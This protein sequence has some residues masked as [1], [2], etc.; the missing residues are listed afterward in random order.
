VKLSA[1]SD[2][3]PGAPPPA[4]QYFRLVEKDFALQIDETAQTVLRAWRYNPRGEFGV[5]YLSSRPECAY[6]EK[7][8]QVFGKKHYLKLQVVGQFEVNLPKCLHLTNPDCLT[9]LGVT[10]EQLIDPSDFSIPQAIAREARRIGFEAILAPAAIGEDCHS[11]IV[12]KDKLS[13]PASCLCHFDSIHD[14][15]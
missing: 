5:L 7:L 14:Y 15:P 13:P 12:F 11:L 10:R 6:R 4:E 2:L 1:L 9:K 3:F 8:K